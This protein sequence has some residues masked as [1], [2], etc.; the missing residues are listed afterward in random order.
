MQA[1]REFLGS[2]ALL[3]LGALLIVAGCPEPPGDDDDTTGA[4]DDD[5]DSGDDDDSAG[6]LDD[7]EPLRA[8]IDASELEDVTV[9]IGTADGVAFV[10]EKG[11]SQSD[12]VYALASASKWLSSVTALRLAE[13]G[14]LTLEDNPQ[15]HLSWWTADAADPRSAITVEQLL[16]FTSGFG[17]DIDGVPCV[18]DGDSTLEACAQEIHDTLH[19]YEPGSTFH[20]GPAHLQVV[21]A[22][23]SA[24]TSRRW[25]RLFRQQ[26]GDPLGMAP[27]TGFALPSLDNPRAAGGGTGSAQD[28]ASFLIALSSGQL[29]SA[30]SLEV[31]AADHTGD[32]VTLAGLPA[33]A[34]D[35]RSWHYGLGCWRECAG[36]THTADCEKPGVLSSPGAFGFYP[37]WDQGRGLWGV[38]AT[39]LIGVGGGAEITVPLGQEWAE[40]AAVALGR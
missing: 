17:G 5:D 29:L 33:T 16:S 26:I 3:A 25:H 27:T 13:E 2:P 11:T 38:V 36:E 32:G 21:A 23:A 35:G 14:T 39:Q 15:D 28:Y 1:H 31:M 30:A 7:W 20:Y 22:M 8:A 4:F 24:A 19:T 10:H 6:G 40:L 18:E 12:T 9:L 37:W 34:M